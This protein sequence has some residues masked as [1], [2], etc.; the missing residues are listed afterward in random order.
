[1]KAARLIAASAAALV[2]A[3]IAAAAVVLPVGDWPGFTA[4]VLPA[5]AD[6]EVA[7]APMPLPP[8][9]AQRVPTPW[10]APPAAV[11]PPAAAVPPPPVARQNDADVVFTLV[12]STMVAL[13]QAD[14]TGNYT[15]L[16]DIS[17]AG[18]RDR[19]SAADLARIFA[20]IRDAK[21]DL[22][23]AVL[24]DPHISKATVNEQK[25]LYVVGAFD[26][27]PL[28]VSFEL[29]FEPAGG[30]WRIFGISVT[31]IGQV[32]D[33]TAT[34][35][36]PPKAAAKSPPKANRAAAPKATV[37]ADTAPQVGNPK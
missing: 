23:Q 30:R 9:P 20:P 26:T 19:N 27:K 34:R 15:V 10:P 36:Q 18:F 33:A 1:M 4:H 22:S 37:P 29:L 17:A 28:P 25:M 31:P 35:A 8:E 21:I 2:A 11:L 5:A 32:G 12:R 6:V 7:Q 13:D 16:R 24:L 3:G 14:V